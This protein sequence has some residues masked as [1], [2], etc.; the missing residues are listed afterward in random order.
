V[1]S[2]TMNVPHIT[3]IAVSQGLIEGDSDI[4]CHACG[5]QSPQA[6]GRGLLQKHRDR[7]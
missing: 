1:S 7:G 2:T 4:G 5:A 6:R 3:A